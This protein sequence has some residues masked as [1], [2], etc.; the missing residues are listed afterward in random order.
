MIFGR[1]RNKIGETT[2]NLDFRCYDSHFSFTSNWLENKAI[3]KK[4]ALKVSDSAH[5]VFAYDYETR[6]ERTVGC[7]VNGGFVAAA[8]FADDGFCAWYLSFLTFV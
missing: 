2:K 5:F 1:N 6:F 3:G 4:D 8:M 7:F